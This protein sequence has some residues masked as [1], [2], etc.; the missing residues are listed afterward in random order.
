LDASGLKLRDRL[1]K[2]ARSLDGLAEKL[3]LPKELQTSAAF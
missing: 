2:V 1:R 3:P